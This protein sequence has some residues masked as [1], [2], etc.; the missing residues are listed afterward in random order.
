MQRF[1]K[2]SDDELQIVWG[3]VYVPDVPDSQ[4]D[5][6]VRDEIMKMAYNWMAKGQ[7]RCIDMEHNGEKV[8]AFVVESFVARKGDPDFIEGAWVVGVHI[9]NV[10]VW[11]AVKKG[12]FNGFSM[13]GRAN[14][15]EAV[16]KE[17]PGEVTGL[18]KA[19]GGHSHEFSVAYAPNGEFIG[20]VTSEVEGHY[21]VIRKGTM[22]EEAAGHSHTFDFVRGI[23]NE[24][25]G[26]A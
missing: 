24:T 12:E 17:V 21:H 9:P 1:I 25:D 5:F 10:P 11:Q 22:T 15:R 4:N 19:E 18:T 6:M 16:D 8:D 7:P 3:E 14:R 26:S 2:K 23:L 13:Y 20:G